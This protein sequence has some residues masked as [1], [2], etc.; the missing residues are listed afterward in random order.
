MIITE[1]SQDEFHSIKENLRDYWGDRYEI[2]IPLHHPLFFHSFGNT[3]FTVKEDEKVCAYLLGFYSQ[4]EPTA[5]VHMINVK[6]P[7]RKKGYATAL[8][9]HFISK[10]K[11]RGMNSIS[12]ITS[13]TNLNSISFHRRLGMRLLGNKN[14]DGIP[15][16]KDYAG[17]GEDRVVFR[18]NI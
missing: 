17:K 3:A 7:Y 15:V 13:P 2:F 10:A 18:M 4:K 12:A 1:M 5:Y 14:S 16:I 8:Y 9:S 11:E 6:E